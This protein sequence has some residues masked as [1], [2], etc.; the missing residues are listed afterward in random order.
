MTVHDGNASHHVQTLR[1][2]CTS[3]ESRQPFWYVLAW[4]ALRCCE[5][6][7]PVDTI[8]AELCWLFDHMYVGTT[9]EAEGVEA[10]YSFL[11]S[12]ALSFKFCSIPLKQVFL[13][14]SNVLA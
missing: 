4:T 10:K 3:P 7:T 8:I 14:V 1:I 13:D 2:S 9:G 5:Q 11:A 6:T 12:G